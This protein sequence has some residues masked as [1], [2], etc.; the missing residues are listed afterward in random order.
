[1]NKELDYL[2]KRVAKGLMTRREFTGRA[3]AL[4]MTAA[5]AS[6][7]LATAVHAEG[8]KKGG[9]LKIGAQGGSTTD[10]LDPALAANFVATQVNLLWGE[11]LVSLSDNGGLDG[12]VAESFEGSADA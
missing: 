9:T 11:P 8:P 12:R 4:G 5:M 6:S 7:M 1:M 3:A 10:S 2:S